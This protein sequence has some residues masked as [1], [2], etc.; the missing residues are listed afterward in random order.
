MTT[1]ITQGLVD[2]GVAGTGPAFSAY[3]GTPQS[4][5]TGQYT[6]IQIN[7]EE[8]DTDNAFDSGTN[9]RFT[10]QVAGYY[11]TR[12]TPRSRP[13]APASPRRW[14]PF[15]KTAAPINTARISRPE[16]QLHRLRA[17]STSTGQPI[18]SS[19]LPIRRRLARPGLVAQPTHSFR[20]YW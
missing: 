8:F 13:T 5:T 12:S 1:K 14:R 20:Q 10:P 4:V 17:W 3:R 19:C 11:T 18:T 2:S 16:L 7:T 6:K 9:Y 15:T